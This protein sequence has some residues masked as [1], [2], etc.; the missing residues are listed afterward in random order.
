MAKSL[1]DRGMVAFQYCDP[2]GNIGTD[3]T[4]NY[5]GSTYAIEGIVSEDGLILGKMGHSERYEPNNF[6]NI[7]G[8][9]DENIFRNAVNYFRKK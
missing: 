3:S 4:Y 5:N 1:F 2:D 8:N 9:K 6:K 7:Y